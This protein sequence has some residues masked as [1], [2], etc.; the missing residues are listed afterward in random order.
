M[1]IILDNHFTNVNVTTANMKKLKPWIEKTDDQI[2]KFNELRYQMLENFWKISL[3]DWDCKHLLYQEFFHRQVYAVIN[4]N[5]F[6]IQAMYFP[7]ESIDEKDF[8]IIKTIKGGSK[9][10]RGNYHF[11]VYLVKYIGS[12]PNKNTEMVLKIY[13]PLLKRRPNKDSVEEDFKTF[14]MMFLFMFLDYCHEINAYIALRI[15]DKKGL[16]AKVPD[17]D[18]VN[19]TERCK[20]H[21]PYLY[22]HGFLS[23][24]SPQ[25][26]EV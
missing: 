4:A 20:A 8:N 5:R 19:G 17:I 18:L 25:I 1:T 13:N 24:K 2:D 26:Y 22:Q 14:R 15:Q 16:Q 12:G 9:S 3:A 23:W 7:S 11:Q 10:E 6:Y 21:V